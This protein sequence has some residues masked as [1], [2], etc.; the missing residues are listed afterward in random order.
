MALQGN[1]A[2][3]PLVDLM[4]V[5]TIQRKT[6]ILTLVQNFSQAQVA[7]TQSRLYSA[8]LWHLTPH[9]KKVHV[10]G[11]PAM[12][13]LMDWQ[14]GQFTF[15]VTDL[16]PPVE[17]VSVPLDYLILEHCRISDE[18]TR[19]EEE[20]W[21]ALR[22]CLVDQPP[23]Q[24]EIRLNL[25]ELRVLLLVN[26]ILTIREIGAMVQQEIQKTIGI[27]R[28]LEKRELIS[29]PRPEPV[30]VLAET[31]QD[32]HQAR[33]AAAPKELSSGLSIPFMNPALDNEDTQPSFASYGFQPQP[34]SKPENQGVVETRYPPLEFF[35]SNQRPLNF[36]PTHQAPAQASGLSPMPA[37]V[38]SPVSANGY[39]APFAPVTPYNRT[40]VE[41]YP[42]F[43]PPLPPF[44]ASN[45]AVQGSVPVEMAP[46]P[47]IK[48]GLLS[49]IMAKI[50]GL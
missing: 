3:L 8:F 20:T 44:K 33:E 26:S 46:R 17:N 22:P 27:A 12:H 2:D 37:W 39:G 4:Q 16:L 47:R 45:P 49:N 50:K 13:E 32:Y 25:D 5:L 6:G 7:F 14:D 35:N 9:G 42:A 11:V 21:G 19:L 48:R 43:V 29:I 28:E 23:D 38:P 1:I 41:P 36:E 34:P 10:E 18:Q 30:A 24:G 15:E 40:A 31:Y